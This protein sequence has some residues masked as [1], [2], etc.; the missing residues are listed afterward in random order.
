MDN[1][2]FAANSRTTAPPNVALTISSAAPSD[3][4]DQHRHHRSAGA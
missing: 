4:T 3:V 1:Q 2:A